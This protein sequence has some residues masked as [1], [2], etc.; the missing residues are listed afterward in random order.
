MGSSFD[1]WM[2]PESLGVACAVLV[3]NPLVNTVYD[4]HCD[5]LLCSG[6]HCL[7][8]F[9]SIFDSKTNIN[10]YFL[11]SSPSETVTVTFFFQLCMQLNSLAA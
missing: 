4:V 3:E 11:S 5:Y 7:G 10:Y 6:D 1:R 9:V 2:A 8:V